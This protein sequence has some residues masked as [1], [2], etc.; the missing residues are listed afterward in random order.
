MDG[1]HNYKKEQV[2]ESVLESLVIHARYS[3][4]KKDQIA[5]ADQLHRRNLLIKATETLCLHTEC[6]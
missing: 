5:Q 4:H 6:K 3:R 1:Y 2:M